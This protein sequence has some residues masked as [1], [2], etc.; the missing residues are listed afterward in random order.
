MNTVAFEGMTDSK[1]TGDEAGGSTSAYGGFMLSQSTELKIH[2]ARE[3]EQPQGQRPA[4]DFKKLVKSSEKNVMLTTN[5]VKGIYLCH[6][7]S[8][9]LRRLFS[10]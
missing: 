7:T 1:G 10:T 6:R 9:C 2:V 8:I 4:E 5:V 3:Q